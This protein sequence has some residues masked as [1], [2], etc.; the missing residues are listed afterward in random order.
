M[1]RKEVIDLKTRREALLRQLQTVNDALEIYMV[2]PTRHDISGESRVEAMRITCLTEWPLGDIVGTRS[3]SYDP[4]AEFDIY[5]VVFET[6]ERVELLR[7][8]TRSE[9]ATDSKMPTPVWKTKSRGNAR[10]NVS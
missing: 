4:L 6:Y 3:S 9:R 5:F 7:I 2:L 10:H 8:T 1:G